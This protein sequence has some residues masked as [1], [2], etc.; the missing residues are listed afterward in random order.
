MEGGGEER[1]GT[2]KNKI[3]ITKG[4]VKCGKK[5]L[6]LILFKCQCNH[7]DRFASQVKKDSI[8]N[9]PITT[10]GNSHFSQ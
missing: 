1:N 3:K 9:I 10:N 6:S 8:L 7:R 5:L 2:Q 4:K